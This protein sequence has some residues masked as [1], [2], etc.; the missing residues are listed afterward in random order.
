MDSKLP[1]ID[2]SEDVEKYEAFSE[3]KTINFR[4]CA[5]LNTQLERQSLKCID[6]PAVWMGARLHELQKLLQGARV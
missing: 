4:Q 2:I 1:P 6:C 3:E 5:H